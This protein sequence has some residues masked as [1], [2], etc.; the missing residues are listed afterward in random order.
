MCSVV[1]VTIRICRLDSPFG[2]SLVVPGFMLL[3]LVISILD[4]IVMVVSYLVRTSLACRLPPRVSEYVAIEVNVTWLVEHE[5]ACFVLVP[6]IV[7][8]AIP[9]SLIGTSRLQWREFKRGDFIGAR[10]PCLRLPSLHHALIA[11]WL[12]QNFS[13]PSF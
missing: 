7:P 8:I 5:A 4:G 11:A 3:V 1:L 10:P 13:N 9:G 2:F 6:P 12:P